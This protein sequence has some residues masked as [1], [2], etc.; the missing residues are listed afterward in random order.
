MRASSNAFPRSVPADDQVV[1][2]NEN[3]E[4][5]ALG[6]QILACF[7]GDDRGIRGPAARESSGDLAAF[8]VDEAHGVASPEISTNA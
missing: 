4:V 7:P 3:G 2:V 1:G 8:R 5:R 6:R